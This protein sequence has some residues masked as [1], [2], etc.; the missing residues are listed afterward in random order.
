[1][2]HV[3]N[4]NMLAAGVINQAVSDYEHARKIIDNK[5]KVQSRQG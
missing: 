4:W 5:K 3:E 1:M 2:V